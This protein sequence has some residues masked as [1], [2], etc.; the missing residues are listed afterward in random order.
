M[1]I[2]F[3][4]IAA[5]SLLS[6]HQFGS[7]QAPATIPDGVFNAASRIQQSLPGSGLARGARIII[8]GVRLGG[9]SRA[10][11]SRGTD[12]WEL[13]VRHV[14]ERQ[15]EAMVPRSVPPGP[16]SLQV[17]RDGERSEAVQ[18][19]ITTSTFGIYSRNG[20]GWGPGEIHDE[21]GAQATSQHA[22]RPGALVSMAGTGLGTASQAEIVVAGLAARVQSIQTDADG[23]DL[24]TFEIPRGVPEGC[25]VPVCGRVAGIMSNTVSIAIRGSSGR[26]FLK[27]VDTNLDIR[28]TSPME[29]DTVEAVR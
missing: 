19:A 24:A 3:P 1:R 23:L 8:E 7:A 11:L 6:T 22:A 9:R 2:P 5:A 28:L 17:V 10:T 26:S 13:P 18:V 25:Y 20:K 16:A 4:L 15:I 21:G 12:Q 14:N 29:P 27:W